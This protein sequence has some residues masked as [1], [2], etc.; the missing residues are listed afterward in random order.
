[1]ESPQ[2]KQR[3]EEPLN[4]IDGD[5]ITT[6]IAHYV[7]LTSVNGRT[8]KLKLRVCVNNDVYIIN[9]GDT[10]MTIVSGS[11]LAGSPKGPMAE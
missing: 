7:L 1:M 4:F 5:S 6:E 8:G 9:T 11:L 10:G 3:T 2:K